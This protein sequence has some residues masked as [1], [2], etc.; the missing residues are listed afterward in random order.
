[1][2]RQPCTQHFIRQDSQMLGVILELD[3]VIATIVAAHQVSLRAAAHPADL[4]NREDHSRAMPPAFANGSARLGI[5]RA[6]GT[7]R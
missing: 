3:D 7:F 2:R 6:A 5:S 4:L 1:M